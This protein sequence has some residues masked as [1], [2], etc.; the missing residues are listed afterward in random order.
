MLEMTSTI[1]NDIV[2]YVKRLNM[3]LFDFK[4]S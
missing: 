3:N 1:M 4:A 2:F